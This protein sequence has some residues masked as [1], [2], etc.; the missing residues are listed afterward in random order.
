AKPFF[1][2]SLAWRAVHVASANAWSCG[3]TG[4]CSV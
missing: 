2:C 3:P 1:W 4:C